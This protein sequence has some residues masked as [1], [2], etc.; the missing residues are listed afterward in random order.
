M[1]LE[2]QRRTCQTRAGLQRGS[3]EHGHFS[4]LIA[5]PHSGTPCR[6]RH[7][8]RQFAI[9]LLCF[10]SSGRTYHPERHHFHSATLGSMPVY[11][12][13]PGDERRTQQHALLVLHGQRRVL[14]R[15]AQVDQPPAHAHLLFGNPFC[16]QPG[17]RFHRHFIKLRLDILFHLVEPGQHLALDKTLDRRMPQ[18]QGAEQARVSGNQ[19]RGGPQPGGHPAGVLSPGSPKGHQRVIARIVPALQ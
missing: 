3:V 11:L 19:H 14:T 4:P 5:P 10:A 16:G 7:P 13:V 8:I 2:D 18:S 6:H 12:L 1:R 9:C 15:E 17:A